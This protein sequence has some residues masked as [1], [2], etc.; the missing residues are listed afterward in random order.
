M[1]MCMRVED[2]LH[3]LAAVTERLP[4]PTFAYTCT[5]SA[6]LVIDFMIRLASFEEF[7]SYGLGSTV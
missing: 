1:S 6:I 5:T 2:H 3:V 4:N 7:K